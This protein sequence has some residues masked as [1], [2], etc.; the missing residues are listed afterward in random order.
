MGMFYKILAIFIAVFQWITCMSAGESYDF[1]Q[2]SAVM[3]LCYI[4]SE[5]YD[6]F[7]KLNGEK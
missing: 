5:I 1:I 6:G 2:V 3:V 4:A 7:N